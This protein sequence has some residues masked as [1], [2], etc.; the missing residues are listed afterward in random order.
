MGFCSPYSPCNEA[1]SLT[2]QAG[3]SHLLRR[4]SFRAIPTRFVR[5]AS[6]A[7]HGL[8]SR[9]RSNPSASPST[10]CVT[11]CYITLPFPKEQIS[12]L[13]ENTLF[14]SGLRVVYGVHSLTCRPL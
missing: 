8:Q 2:S 12:L 13:V 7:P 1:R 3:S 14:S 6:V 11:F 9:R 4:I 5:R 10:Q